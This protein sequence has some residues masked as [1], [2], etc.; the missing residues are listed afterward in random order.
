MI[1]LGV[2]MPKISLYYPGMPNRL[3]ALAI[4]LKTDEKRDD[5]FIRSV[6]TMVF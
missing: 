5:I 2:D 4:S 6:A 1:H 3:D